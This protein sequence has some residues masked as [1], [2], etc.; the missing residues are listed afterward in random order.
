M[1]EQL[2]KPAVQTAKRFPTL[3][4]EAGR[5]LGQFG[6]G[7]VQNLS[8]LRDN[9][10]ILSSAL[11]VSG[12]IGIAKNTARK[13]VGTSEGPYRRRE[14]YKTALREVGGFAL[15]YALLRGV[16]L[17]ATVGLKRYLGVSAMAKA[18]HNPF[19]GVVKTLK[20]LGRMTAEFLTGNPIT[21]TRAI[22]IEQRIQWGELM[23]QLVANPAKASRVKALEPLINGVH[24]LFVALPAPTTTRWP[25][26][27]SGPQCW[28]VWYRLLP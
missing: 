10:M 8:L 15:S 19:P 16:Q 25:H 24:K 11:R 5:L 18:G 1:I 3:L 26:S 9:A 6:M 28:P 22:P 27:S 4:A 17:A 12:R 14:F 21:P 2:L 20:G 13:S 7:K 23:G